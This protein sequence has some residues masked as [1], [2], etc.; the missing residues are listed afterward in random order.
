MPFYSHAFLSWT[1]P[2]GDFRQAFLH[3]FLEQEAEL[4]ESFFIFIYG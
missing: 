3:F 1:N 4:Q 2:T